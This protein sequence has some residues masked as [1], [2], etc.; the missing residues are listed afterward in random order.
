MR[1]RLSALGGFR[2]DGAAGPALPPRGKLVVL[3]TYL[4][5]RSPAAVRREELAALLWGDRPEPLARQSL[6]HALLRLRRSIGEQVLRVSADDARLLP[7]GFD[8]DVA[9][10]ETAVQDG[11]AAD[12]VACWRGEFLAGLEDAGSE[13]FRLWLEAEREGLRRKLAFALEQ[14][15]GEAEHRADWETGVR[16]AERWVQA[17]PFDEAAHVRRLRL[18]RLAGRTADALAEHARLLHWYREDLGIEPCIA[19]IRL[20]A[21]LE[22]R[23]RADQA[24]SDHVTPALVGRDTAFDALVT[25]WRIA[26]AGGAT[27]VVVD[28]D[29]GS[30][31]TRLLQEFLAWHAAETPGALVLHA[32]ATPS[33]EPASTA[34]EL[35]AGLRGAAG[36]SGAADTAL[37]LVAELVPGIRDRFPRLP[38]AAGGGTA[39]ARAVADVL[40][41]V[42]AEQP[43]LLA[44]DDFGEADAE[45]ARL[46]LELAAGVPPGVM[47]VLTV[48]SALDEAVID[49]AP[50]RLRRVTL[51]PLD[52]A[53]IES[54]LDSM[55]PVAAADRGAVA[56]RIHDE[57]AGNPRIAVELVRALVATGRLRPDAD[58][59]WSQDPA[60]A[61]QPLPVPESV[62]AAVHAR[63]R[64]LSARDRVVLDAIA[65]LGGDADVPSLSA[66]SGEQGDALDAALAAL[67]RLGL[68]RA[69]QARIRV[70]HECSRR[71]VVDAIPPAR[72]QALHDAALAALRGRD[73]AADAVDAEPVRRRER[74]RW[75]R[76]RQAIAAALILVVGTALHASRQSHADTLP[77]MAIGEVLDFTGEDSASAALPLADLLATRLARLPRLGVVS[78]ERMYELDAQLTG[79]SGA[80]SLVDAARHAGASQVV[81]GAMYRRRG[82]G[83]R[84]ELRRIDLTTGAVI[85]GHIVDALDAVSLVDGAVAEIAAEFALSVPPSEQERPASI[86]AYRMYEEGLR[87]YY[88]GDALSATNFFGAALAEDSTFVMAA[89][90]HWASQYWA[91][92]L[93]PDSDHALARVL[94]LASHAPDRERLMIHA[95][96]AEHTRSAA[97]LPLADTLAIRYPLEPDGHFLLGRARAVAGDFLG[98]VPH[99]E[100]VLAMDSLGFTG[101]SLRCR[102]CDAMAQLVA[103]YALADSM[104]AAER[105]A[106]RWTRLQPDAARP[107]VF[108]ASLL[109]YQERFDDALHARRRAMPHQPANRTDPAYPGIIAVRRGDFELADRL[110][111]ERMNNGSTRVAKEAAWF[112]VISL[113]QQGRLEE[114]LRVAR[115]H[116]DGI[117][118]AVVLMEMDSAHAAAER[119]AALAW[120]V[121][122]DDVRRYRAP[123]RLTHFASAHAA[124][125]D[126]AVLLPT[127]DTIAALAQE[128]GSGRDRRLPQYIRGRALAAAGDH[129]AAIA[130]F[131]RAMHSRTNGYVLLNLHHARS[132][133]ATGEP[134]AAIDLLRAPLRG[135]LDAGNF[136]APHTELRVALGAAYEAAGM[137]DSAA[138]Q[139][140]RVLA[141]WRHADHSF[142]ARRD[143]VQVRL[144]ALRML[145]SR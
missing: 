109:E 30:G 115:A 46:L 37:G 73:A 3:L 26:A 94:E 101:T 35:L 44:V 45:S 33:R 116:A 121:E 42:A 74:R 51:Q 6:R 8:L 21:E 143:S 112:M 104:A 96:W 63:V 23:P 80:S 120:Q 128:S 25:G 72:R 140:S 52:A 20:G 36:L 91:A 141:A 54:L 67:S 137:P 85:A 22:Q 41:D 83:L 134:L 133:I 59:T 123:W 130:E 100:R 66:V 71:A 9:E 87:A 102:A 98:A 107:W 77:T 1:V 27:A 86:V 5:R 111:L 28:G 89:F 55:L 139:Y 4:A 32:A 69:D 48:R 40:G 10:F 13:A 79:L 11:R 43:V 93:T 142:S 84:L 114:A 34:R 119:F 103:T 76:L 82:G 81:Q 129:V 106:R 95:L 29:E 12:A 99:F 31:R 117:A 39:T 118:E 17:Q 14:L 78:P 47:L 62:R 58:A 18:L 75:S 65:V 126:H 15:V 7:D 57:S 19:L 56:H 60:R 68:L 108:L 16:L 125:G 61:D 113:R 131:E 64:T 92:L 2:L 38:A 144:E 138:A 136:Y 122:H 105:A 88:R 135:P 24:G 145:R 97:A 90:Y 132:L 49:I 70:P 127:A 50:D 110:L 53:G 124:G